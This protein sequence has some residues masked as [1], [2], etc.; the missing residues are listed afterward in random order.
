AAAPASFSSLP[1]LSLP[2][3]RYSRAS[4][5][6]NKA[7]P[8]RRP[9]SAS[10]MSVSRS[11]A[12]RKIVI[13]DRQAFQPDRPTHATLLGGLFFCQHQ[14]IGGVGTLRRGLLPAGLQAFESVVANRFE[15]HEP[16]FIL[17]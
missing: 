8:R 4:Q 3:A 10:P 14:A 7:A 16:R 13:F 12:A 17:R 11:S 5:K 15:H 6:R 1:S 9:H 2:S